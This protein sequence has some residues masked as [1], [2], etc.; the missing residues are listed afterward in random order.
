MVMQWR[1]I[2]YILGGLVVGFFGIRTYRYFFD[3]TQPIL[4]LRGIEQNGYYAG[5]VQCSIASSKNG[6]LSI[7]LDEQPLINQ[8]SM[9]GGEHGHFFTIPTKTI[10]NGKHTLRAAITDNTFQKNAIT[11]DRFFYVDN[12][13]LQAALVKAENEY[14]VFQGR[15]LHVQFQI[16]KDIKEATITALSNTYTCFPE[17]KNSSIYEAFIPVPCEEN[18]NEYLFS[19]AIT[20]KVGSTIRLDNKF[21]VVM[22]P[23]KRHQLLV[24][25][26]KVHEESELGKDS[27]QFEQIIQELTQSSPKEKLWKGAFC[28]PIE[29]QRVSTDFGTIRTTQHKGRY[30]HKALDVLNVPKSVVWAPQDGIVVMKDRFAMSGNTVIIDHGYGILSLFFHLDDFAKIEVGQKIAKGNP[31]GTIGK[32]G[33]ASG[34]HL[35]WEMRVNNVAIDPMQWTKTIF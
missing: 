2:G 8:F 10:S 27:S 4:V 19:V 29:I 16:N 25:D 23:F 24:S 33:Y 28:T 21:Q 3:T 1:F 32:S 12:V 7:W 18:P 31:L 15:T 35:H 5:D 9:N 26:E 13:P 22:F 14:K 17:S 20:D 6:E 11:I 34:Y 30:A